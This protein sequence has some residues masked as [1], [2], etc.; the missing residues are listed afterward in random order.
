MSVL[1]L[2][3]H[4]QASFGKRN[5]DAL[6]D[7]GHDQSRLL[8]AAWAS[9]GIVPTR[10]VRGELRRHAETAEGIVEGLGADVEIV[11][12]AGW[13]EFNF[14][15]VMRVHKPLY[16]SRTLMLADFARVPAAERRARFQA[17]FEEATARWSGG[18]SDHDYDEPFSAFSQRVEKALQ[19]T[20]ADAQGTVAV[21]SSGG[22]IGFAASHLLAGDGSVW[23]AFNRVAVNTG[24]TKLLTGRSGITLSAY[25]DHS[26]LEHDRALITYR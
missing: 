24:V 1:L 19:R 26:H 2:V 21:V 23:A 11:V 16:R 22:P 15:H 7:A 20:A 9:R 10:I 18:D 13:D 8:G 25:N 14:E 4:G 6:S 3:R 12:D 5:Y 17:L